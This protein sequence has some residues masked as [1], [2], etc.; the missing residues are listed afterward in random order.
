[1]ESTE[2]PGKTAVHRERLLMECNWSAA[3]TSN[4]FSLHEPSLVLAT[5]ASATSNSHPTNANGPRWNASHRPIGVKIGFPQR[6][7]T[8]PRPAKTR[9][10]RMDSHLRR[11]WAER[12]WQRPHRARLCESRGT[13]DQPRTR[14]PRPTAKSRFRHRRGD[15]RPKRR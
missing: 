3:V 13:L 2:T 4:I 5:T 12:C 7:S 8:P 9:R 6:Q 14:D 15:R 1:M 11:H 10:S